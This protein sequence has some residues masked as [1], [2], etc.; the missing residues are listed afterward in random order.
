MKTHETL[1]QQEFVAKQMKRRRM[2]TYTRILLLV[3]ILVLWEFAAR[4]GLIND[5]IFSSPS[6]IML[7]FA[8][9]VLDGSVFLHTG[10]TILETLISFFLVT[11][12]GIF[13]AVALWSNKSLSEI[14]DPYLVMLNSLPK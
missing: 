4:T 2:V 14:L 12:I 6:R 7:T 10:I 3:L 8:S 9:M 1:A 13:G 11:V 5:F